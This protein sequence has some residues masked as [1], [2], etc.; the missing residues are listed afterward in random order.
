MCVAA[1]CPGERHV[2]GQLVSLSPHSYCL[3][4]SPGHVLRGTL[5]ADPPKAIPFPRSPPG[6]TWDV[7]F[8]AAGLS[9][10]CCVT[11]CSSCHL[12]PV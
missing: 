4:V 12:C 7:P 10:W 5:Q 1:A 9:A 8:P 6:W 3:G 11:L 2:E